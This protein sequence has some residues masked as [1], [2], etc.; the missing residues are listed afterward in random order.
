MEAELITKKTGRAM[1]M[2]WN[3]SSEFRKST[4]C[5]SSYVLCPS[6][7]DKL[8]ACWRIVVVEA[9]HSS[10]QIPGSLQVTFV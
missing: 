7:V 1:E 6:Q 2:N 5:S 3:E 8:D 9:G 10:K 4:Y